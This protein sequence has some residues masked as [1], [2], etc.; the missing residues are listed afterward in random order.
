MKNQKIVEPDVFEIWWQERQTREL[1]E[2]DL[3]INKVRSQIVSLNRV[4]QGNRKS[5]N[6]NNYQE[7]QWLLERK[8]KEHKKVYK[9]LLAKKEL[10][11]NQK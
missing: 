6:I 4:Y 8:M 11:K 1:A 5:P 10:I 7:Q 3:E 9:Q 2:V